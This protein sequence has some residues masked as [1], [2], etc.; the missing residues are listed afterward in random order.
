MEMEMDGFGCFLG[1][2][3]SPMCACTE[4]ERLPRESSNQVVR[5]T[6]LGDA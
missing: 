5:V 1:M 4:W 2:H 3:L 6:R